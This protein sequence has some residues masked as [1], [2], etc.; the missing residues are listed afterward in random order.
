MQRLPQLCRPRARQPGAA[1]THEAAQV[2]RRHPKG[3]AAAVQQ[4]RRQNG[5][6][7]QGE[8]ASVTILL[9]MMCY[10]RWG[11]TGHLRHPDRFHSCVR[12][13]PP[14]HDKWLVVWR[15]LCVAFSLNNKTGSIHSCNYP[16]VRATTPS[17]V[18]SRGG[19]G[20]F[21]IFKPEKNQ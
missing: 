14:P 6:G 18:P 2:H 5:R 16:W 20:G 17:H 4:L 15:R 13:Q 1:P 8:Q 19:G 7:A 9:V 21:T 3:D 12:A 10:Y 11:R